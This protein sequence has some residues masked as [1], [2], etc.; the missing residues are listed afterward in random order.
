MEL[1]S[2]I[3]PPAIRLNRANELY[4]LRVTTLSENHP[5]RQRTPYTFPPGLETGLDIDENHYLDWNQH[6]HSLV[7]KKHSTQLIRVLYSLCKL[8]PNRMDLEVSSNE[9]NN[10]PWDELPP[11]NIQISKLDKESTVLFEI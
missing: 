9:I 1:E 4:A 2:A 3:L 10:S 5:I 8:L 6:P 11:V 7:R